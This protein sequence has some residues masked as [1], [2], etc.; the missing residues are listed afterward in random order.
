MKFLIVLLFIISLKTLAQIGIGT[1]NPHQSSILEI[2]S[3]NKGLLLPR[4]SKAEANSII[5][6]AIGLMV[7][8][9]NCCENG[10]LYSY[11]GDEWE[12][13]GSCF[14]LGTTP[15]STIASI[16]F[17]TPN[18]HSY[19]IGQPDF[20]TGS[21]QPISNHTFVYPTAIQISTDGKV[22]IVDS[23][24]NRILRYSNFNN[25]LFNFPAEYVFGQTN[26]TD[27]NT[28]LD[29]YK[30]ESPTSMIIDNQGTLW[31]TDRYKDR[32]LGFNNASTIT[33][34][35]PTPDFVIGANS[36]VTF[37]T[38]GLTDAQKLRQ[39]QDLALDNDGNIWIGSNDGRLLHYNRNT[40]PATASAAD[41]V[42]GRPDF[43]ILD[44]PQT[45]SA[46]QLV[47]SSAGLIVAKNEDLY[48]SDYFGN[49][50]L[51]FEN[52]NTKPNGTS[53][54][55][56]Y[57]QNSFTTAD[58]GTSNQHLNGAGGLSIDGLGNLYVSDYKNHRVMVI[59]DIENAPSFSPATQQIGQ[60]DF[61]SNIPNTSQ[62]GLNNPFLI[63]NIEYQG[64]TLIAISDIS[65]NRIVVFGGSKMELNEGDSTTFT[66]K[67]SS[68]A[69]DTTMLYHIIQQPSLGVVSLLEHATG[70]ISIDLSGVNVNTNTID[71]FVFRV[72]DINGVTKE[73]TQ[74]FLIKNN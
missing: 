15:P 14:Q 2:A 28:S 33:A 23:G 53:A 44:F 17:E 66:L 69:T 47:W 62:T 22:F 58:T 54:E 41:R 27:G 24:N 29:S 49:R 40:M 72:E 73:I 10:M 7:Y 18:P 48:V 1:N 25:F 43:N 67:T 12:T 9:E 36:S 8:C 74:P 42:L 70:T 31:V 51:V 3:S 26:F 34:V 45:P 5:N 63:K 50:I 61:N 57:F 60:L 13:I 35:P 6:P 65:N 52:A 68:T 19:V 46:S 71:E 64:Q 38:T 21:F 59:E 32:V 4:L 37:D 16:K 39:P 20:V 55:R 11:N 30:L 56:I